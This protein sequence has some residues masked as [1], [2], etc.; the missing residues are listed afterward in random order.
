MCDVQGQVR[1]VMSCMADV[2]HVVWR[3][4]GAWGVGPASIWLQGGREVGRVGAGGALRGARLGGGVSVGVGLH[5]C[6]RGAA[7]GAASWRHMPRACRSPSPERAGRRPNRKGAEPMKS[8]CHA[9]RIHG[10]SEKMKV[11]CI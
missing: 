7:S 3:G 6:R 10:D 11:L 1:W 8:N 5:L 9:S 2:G 4:L